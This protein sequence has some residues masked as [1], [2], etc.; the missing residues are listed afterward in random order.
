M[1]GRSPDPN[2]SLS[3]SIPLFPDGLLHAMY[4]SKADRIALV[5][6]FTARCATVPAILLRL[7]LALFETPVKVEYH[8]FLFRRA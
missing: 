5:G 3:L 2:V 8:L 1:R 7:L 4:D 6:C